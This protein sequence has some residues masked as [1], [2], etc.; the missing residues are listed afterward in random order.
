MKMIDNQSKKQIFSLGVISSYGYNIISIIVGIFSI[1]IG[2]KYF[3]VLRF[4]IWSVIYSIIYYLN[5]SNFGIN[6]SV[7]VLVAKTKNKFVQYSIVKKSF[8]LTLFSSIFF[9]I[10]FLLLNYFYSNWV[11]IVGKFP[12]EYFKETS[13]T[14]LISTIFFL[15][16]FPFSIFNSAF[17]GHQKIYIERFYAILKL[18]FEFVALLIV[19]TIKGNLVSLAFY[20]GIFWIFIGIISVIHYLKTNQ[21]FFNRIDNNLSDTEWSSK[22]IFNSGVKFFFLTI[23]SLIIWNTDN[24]VISNLLGAQFVTSYT[25]TFKFYSILFAILMALNSPLL[26]MYGNASVNNQWNWIRETYRNFIIIMS[27]I[28]GGMWIFG[29]LFGEVIIKFWAGKEAYGGILIILFI[30]GWGYFLSFSL[31]NNSLLSGLNLTKK[32]SLVSWLEAIVNI[33]ISIVFV[34]LIGISGAALGTFLSVIITS[35]WLMSLVI[36]KE[37]C[38]NISINYF[39]I[40]KKHFFIILIPLVALSLL[41]E[42]YLINPYLKYF[43]SIIVITLYFLFSWLLLPLDVKIFIK[44]NFGKIFRKKIND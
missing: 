25:V 15:I 33:I 2:L 40:S 22:N 41:I 10:F 16:S 9:I 27:N 6:T 20:R 34:K 23:S 30:G 32:Y 1:P 4:G 31:V 7:M 35:F 14:I 43:S 8:I 39:F 44:Q 24:I 42:H 38:G 5:L 26:P 18:I 28:A 29:L 37:T 36:K 19:V 11:Y 21:G 12:I 3:G 17:S 13:S